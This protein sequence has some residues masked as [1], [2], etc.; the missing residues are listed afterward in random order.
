M[1]KSVLRHYVPVIIVYKLTFSHAIVVG[2][3]HEFEK[4]CVWKNKIID[5]KMFSKMMWF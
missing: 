5:D 2:W 3:R 1:F 4:R